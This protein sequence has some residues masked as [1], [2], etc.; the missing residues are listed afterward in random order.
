MGKVLNGKSAIVTGGLRGIGK[1]AAMAFAQAGANVAAFDLDPEDSPLVKEFYGQMKS[2]GKKYLYQKADVFHY[3]EVQNAVTKTIKSFG[4]LDILV[5]NAGGGMNPC[6]LEDL[7]EK[8]WDR[9]LD[10]NLK[11]TYFCTK[12]VIGH[13][14]KKKSGSIINV[15]SQAGRS[16]SELSN[17]TYASAKAGIIGFTRQLALETGPLGI[18][19]NAVAPGV[20]ISG[21]RVAKRWEE[22]SAEEKRAMLEAIPLR[23]LGQPEE[24][25]SVILFLASD[26]ASYITGAVIDVNGGRFML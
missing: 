14:K 20:T 2:F 12:A 13:M 8:D 17:I 21:E 6:P 24:I 25:A 1:A 23:R 3:A 4:D 9:I 18:R 15:S 16:K 19:V 5:N 10:L 22:R 26:A 11:G 7:E